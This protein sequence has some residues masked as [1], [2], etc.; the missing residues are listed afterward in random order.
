MLT[1]GN[2][3]CQQKQKD[4][5][6]DPLFSFSEHVP[7]EAESIAVE[8]PKGLR[9]ALG[10]ELA[11]YSKQK[12][13]RGLDVV[14]T[15]SVTVEPNGRAMSARE[16][17]RNQAGNS[18]RSAGSHDAS[19]PP[20]FHDPAMDAIIEERH[21]RAHFRQERLDQFDLNRHV[22]CLVNPRLV[23][24]WRATEETESKVTTPSQEYK[25][26]IEYALELMQNKTS[27]VRAGLRAARKER[28]VTPTVS[29]ARKKVEKPLGRARSRDYWGLTSDH[30]ARRNL[31]LVPEHSDA[32][33]DGLP[34]QELMFRRQLQQVKE[35]KEKEIHEAP[36]L[37]S[38]CSV[39]HILNEQETERKQE[40]QE[41]REKGRQNLQ[42]VKRKYDAAREK[43]QQAQ[44][45]AAAVSKKSSFEQF[46]KESRSQA[47]QH[48]RLRIAERK[49][50]E[51]RKHATVRSS[52]ANIMSLGLSRIKVPGAAPPA[53]ASA[54]ADEKEG[55]AAQS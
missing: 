9:F 40:V 3:S 27:R 47:A 50:E 5:Q 6:L 41:V 25:K 24:S 30:E 7:K 16:K 29:M 52:L 43:F 12:R 49:A 53:G 46:Y 54:A 38:S 2:D 20:R 17:I 14:K 13:E 19:A 36:L 51:D 44:L 8:L 18:A 21:G 15:Y 35:Q 10:K 31:F 28:F 37:A 23:P 32:E 42:E 45:E 1:R 55:A 48:E 33:F 34:C 22:P 11:G 39:S 4:A 26:K